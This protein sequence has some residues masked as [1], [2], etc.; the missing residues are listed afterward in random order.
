ME[1]NFVA[2]TTLPH[3]LGLRRW[4]CREG[5]KEEHEMEAIRQSAIDNTGGQAL[6][7]T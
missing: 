2:K 1:R 4:N 7:P 6:N 5:T 3:P